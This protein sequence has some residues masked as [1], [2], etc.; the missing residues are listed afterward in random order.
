VYA[1]EK[2]I[3]FSR[4][5]QYVFVA[6]SIW[7][8][9][10]I[11]GLQQELIDHI[12]KLSNQINIIN[13]EQKEIAI[14]RTELSK[15]LDTDLVHPDRILNIQNLREVSSTPRDLVEDQRLDNH[16]IIAK[17][18]IKKSREARRK[19]TSENFNSLPSTKKLFKVTKPRQLSKKEKR[20]S[21]ALFK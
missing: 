15:G 11:I 1:L 19:F 18:V 9:S 6:Q 2:I 17:Q 12:D 10:L 3:S 21:K 20:K 14:T 4:D 13:N 5:N 7:W 16:L 8:I